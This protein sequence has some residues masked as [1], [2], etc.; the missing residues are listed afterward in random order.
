MTGSKKMAK[1][2]NVLEMSATELARCIRGREL[3]SREV[4][5][6]HIEHAQRVNPKLNAIVADRY[7]EALAEAEAADRLLE[8]SAGTGL[9]PLHGVPCTVKECFALTGMPQT[10]GLYARR[11]YRAP[12][13]ATVVARLRA[14][15]AIPIGVTNTSELCMWIE[16][17]NRVYG[18]SNN[19][20]DQSRIVGGSSGGEGA[21]IGAGASPFGVGSDVGGSIRGPAF[22][23]GVFGHKPTGGLVPNTGQFPATEGAAMRYLTTGPLSRR[24]QDLMPLLR[25][26]AGP[27]GQDAGCDAWP[28]GDPGAVS[29]AGLRVLH[30]PDNGFTPVSEALREAQRQAAHHLVS[31]GAK[32]EHV[33]F[34][35]FARSLEIWAAMLADSGGTSFEVLLGNGKEMLLGPEFLRWA[36]GR[37]RH[38]LPALSLALIERFV[39][40]SPAQNARFIEQGRKLR[41]EL[42][43]A[44]GPDGVLLFPSYSTVAPKHSEPLFPPIRWCYAAIFNVLELPATAV[45]LGLDTQGLPLGV[46]VV[47]AHGNDHVTIA[48]AMEL[49]RAFGGW[50]RPRS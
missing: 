7:P 19:P 43:E 20:Y 30:V 2:L 46:Q 35:R 6:A 21:I 5:A 26:M 49:E 48:V 23:N 33:R 8:N 15:G 38:T 9:G 1:P 42:L 12:T 24:A 28:L 50:V 31:R 29:M 47:S 14:A 16:S 36:L 44:L 13:D 34:E 3:S 32:V 41:A 22:F 18:R 4:V 40:G 10:A 11:D 27:D 25:L 45:P 17:N 37:S 39:K